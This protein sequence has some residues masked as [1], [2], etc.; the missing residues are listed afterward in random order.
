MKK[1]IFLSLFFLVSFLFADDLNISK[2][3]N[4]TSPEEVVKP[5]YMPKVLYV[6]F[7]DIPKRVLK[8]EIFSITI[9][10]L[11]TLQDTTDIL[12]EFSNLYGLKLFNELPQRQKDS[13]YYYDTF[14][15]LTTSSSA[16]LPDI[17]ANVRT[18]DETPHKSAFLSGPKLNVI[19]LNPKNNFSN[20]IAN[21][22]SLN[23]Y[24]TTTYDDNH[25]IIV[26]MATAKNCDI[27]SMKFKNVFKQGIESIQEGYLES[28]ITYYIVI[29]KEIKNFTFSYFNLTTNRYNLVNIPIIVNDDSVTTQSDLKPKD[30]SR[31]RLKM[32]IAAGVALFGFV[33]ILWRKKYIYL[34]FII[35]PLAYIGYIAMPSKILCIKQGAKIHLLPVHNGTIF[36]TTQET[37]HLQKEGSIEGFVKVKL[38]NDKIG[39]VSDE[40]ICSY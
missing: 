10:S 36:Q 37:I 35:I 11:S 5:L 31:E 32:Y 33:F 2:E 30:Q 20:I 4:A 23:E 34:V 12:Y 9:K 14:Y 17:T 19:T 28:K 3:S 39:W 40:D 6:N 27:K 8:G 15:F 7:Q 25:N 38:Q 1:L 24:K 18:Y 26:F 22:F 21:S 29:N 16:K 13:K